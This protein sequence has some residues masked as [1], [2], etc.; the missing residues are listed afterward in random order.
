M[1]A[2]AEGDVRGLAAGIEAVG[3]GKLRGIAVGRTDADM[4]VGAGRQPLAADLEVGR[5]RRLPSWLELSKR[6]TF[7]DRSS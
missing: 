2:R 5:K 1:H 6:S 3:L 7:L 4:D